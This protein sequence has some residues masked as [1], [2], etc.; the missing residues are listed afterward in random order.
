M[1]LMRHAIDYA[2]VMM[3]LLFIDAT[4]ARCFYAPADAERDATL[5]PM[6]MM[7]DAIDAPMLRCCFV[8]AASASQRDMSV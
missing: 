1:L 2:A 5:M 6:L 7:R 3:I 8:A 4:S